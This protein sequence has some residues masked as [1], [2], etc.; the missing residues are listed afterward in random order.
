MTNNRKRT[1]F[2]SALRTFT[3]IGSQHI[4][5]MNPPGHRPIPAHDLLEHGRRW[6]AG[7]Q[8]KL[9]FYLQTLPTAHLTA[10]APPLSD[11]QWYYKCNMLESSPNYPSHL[12]PLI[13]GKTF[14][15]KTGHWCQKVW[16]LLIYKTLCIPLQQMETQFCVVPTWRW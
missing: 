3:L 1:S 8:T 4:N 13:C 14:F 10:W 15:Y 7:K 11:Q 12:H 5:F 2:W 6:A 9:H 16:E